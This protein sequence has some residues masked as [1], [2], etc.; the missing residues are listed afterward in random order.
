VDAN[1]A[2]SVLPVDAPPETQYTVSPGGSVVTDAVTG[3]VWQR[4]TLANPCPSD[5][6]GGTGSAGCTWSDA[7]T[8]CASLN[9]IP[10][11]GYSV[12]WRL[13]SVAELL[14]VVNYAA[15][16]LIDPA[17]FSNPP[18]ATFWAATPNPLAA[19]LAYG[20]SFATGQST[21][22]P[23]ATVSDVRCV[24]SGGVTP[25]PEGCGAVS[26]ACCYASTCNAA[27]LCNAGT[28]VSDTNYALW[29]LPA[30]APP[31][32]K[33]T[34][35]GGAATD[36]VTG[37][38]WAIQPGG[39]TPCP[40]DGAGGCTWAH[41]STLCAGLDTAGL[42]GLTGGWRQPSVVELLSLVNYGAASG[43]LI[44]TSVFTGA[45]AVP[46]WTATLGAGT[47]GQAWSVDLSTGF[48]TVAATGTAKMPMCV[49]SQ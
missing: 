20:V 44:D 21:V 34:T 9:A 1:Y 41:A 45:T 27:L 12:G 5:F 29:T 30:D 25:A 18:S 38:V 49:N 7:Q 42:A 32:A 17:P 33:Y 22:Q 47:T 39:S 15:T 16:P 31:A 36:T 24:S 23:T 6:D 8:Y 35:S 4:Q 13:P 26:Q 10:L 28:C 2:Q 46:Y 40:G 3:L 11:G 43:P 48:N 37:L 19:G 14:S